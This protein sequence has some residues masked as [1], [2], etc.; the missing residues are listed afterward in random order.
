MALKIWLDDKL[1]DEKDAKISVN[2]APKAIT[3]ALSL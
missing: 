3:K 1:V 2:D